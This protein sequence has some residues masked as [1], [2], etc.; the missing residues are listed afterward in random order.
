MSDPLTVMLFGLSNAPVAFQRF[1][2]KIFAN[3]L[4]VFMVVYLDNILIYLDDHKEH[5][6]EVLR[7]LGTHKLFTSPAKCTFYQ[8]SVEFLGFILSLEEV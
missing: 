8:N 7:R 3:L 6:K 4:D 1:M 5:V 2:N